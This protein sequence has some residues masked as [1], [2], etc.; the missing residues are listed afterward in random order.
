MFFRSLAIC[1]T[2]F[3]ALTA[4]A[5]CQEPE[6]AFTNGVGM[7]FILI[8][9]G[10]FFMGS[11][12]AKDVS[13]SADEVPR[14]KV[15]I[16]RDFFLS[17]TEVTQA[18][19]DKV[20]GS[21]PSLYRGDNRPVELVTWE[22]AQAFLKRLNRMEGVS[23]YRLPTEAEWEYAA[24][25]GTETLYHFGSEKE[26]LDRYAWYLGDSQGSTHEVGLKT[27]NQFGL[28]DMLGNVW[29][30]VADWYDVYRE[31]GQVTDPTGPEV[32]LFRVVRGGSY[33]DGPTRLRS[34]SRFF[35][36]SDTASDY[37]G[38]RVAMDLRPSMQAP[39]LF[40]MPDSP[41]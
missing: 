8:Q 34:A 14:H 32:G 19:W 28:H 36:G 41:Q 24:R 18:Q 29:E 16:S 17:K 38:F 7:E 25:A 31:F 6:A 27:P 33:E 10:S 3:L 26:E 2:V 1:L 15:T 13:A 22:D 30:F 4:A 12:R 11:D 37:V 5:P 40:P 20:M 35:R 21:N 39:A 9:H 23:L